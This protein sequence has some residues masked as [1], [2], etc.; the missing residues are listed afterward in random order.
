MCLSVFISAAP[1]YDTSDSVLFHLAD[2]NKIKKKMKKQ[3][4][5]QEQEQEEERRRRR[6]SSSKV[7]SIEMGAHSIA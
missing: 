3:E 1:H 7:Y 4:Q 6:K 5:E 2:N